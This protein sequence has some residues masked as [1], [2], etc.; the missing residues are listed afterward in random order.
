MLLVLSRKDRHSIKSVSYSIKS[1][2]ASA[3]PC[4]LS[5]LPGKARLGLEEAARVQ[6]VFEEDGTAVEDEEFF[7][8][9]NPHTVLMLIPPGQ[10]WIDSKPFER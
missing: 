3:L 5:I 9:L 7:S 4:R 6:V 8:T 1:V 2:L 10:R